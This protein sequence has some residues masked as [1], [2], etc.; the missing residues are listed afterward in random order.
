MQTHF[1]THFLLCFSHSTECDLLF[2]YSSYNSCKHILLHIPI[3]IKATIRT[4]NSKER[5]RKSEGPDEIFGK[6]P[7][8]FS[9]AAHASPRQP[10]LPLTLSNSYNLCSLV[11][12]RKWMMCCFIHK[13]KFHHLYPTFFFIHFEL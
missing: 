12:E 10:K 8:S 1:V 9:N 4:S 7:S 6:K 3:C 5:G 11:F 13:P 2:L